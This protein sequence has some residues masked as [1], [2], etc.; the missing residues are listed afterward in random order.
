[1]NKN[2]YAFIILAFS[3]L[4]LTRCSAKKDGFSSE[5]L[6]A[7]M[8]LSVGKYVTYQLDSMKFVNFGQAD[9]IIKYQ[10]KDVI[11]TAITDNLGRPAWR[12]IRYLNDTLASG[13]WTPDMT[14]MIVPTTQ[15]IEVI[16]N[17][18]RFQK[19]KL[20]I[21]N[22][23]SW[24]GNTFIDTYSVNSD[25]RY[26]DNWDYT[27]ANVGQAYSTVLNCI[28]INQRDETLG[29]INNVDAYSERNYSQEIYGKNIGLVYKSFLHWVF[30]P[31]NST[32]P[33]GYKEGYGITLQ[34]I[35][36]N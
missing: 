32:Y 18:M 25:V 24:K 16:E 14:Y 10:A 1:M 21:V 27:Y 31:R 6:T 15:T 5:T 30:Q 8:N 7:Y 3:G 13:T 23:F 35:D 33:N 22:E 19:L 28:T 26:L 4:L 17:N 12:V 36:H 2:I 34:M 11:D 9:T 20:P 29:T